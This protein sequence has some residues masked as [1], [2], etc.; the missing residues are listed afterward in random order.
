MPFG[1]RQNTQFHRGINNPLRPLAMKVEGRFI[2]AKKAKSDF[3][4]ARNPQKCVKGSTKVPP[5]T[6]FLKVALRLIADAYADCRPG[7]R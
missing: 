4:T 1:V 6:I 5:K 2:V 3:Q 7:Q